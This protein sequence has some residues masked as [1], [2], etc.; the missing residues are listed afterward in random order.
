MGLLCQLVWALKDVTPTEGS[1]M[2][3][4]LCGLWLL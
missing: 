3:T 4:D 2:C 1:V